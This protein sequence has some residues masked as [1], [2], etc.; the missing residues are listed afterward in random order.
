MAYFIAVFYP[1]EINVLVVLFSFSSSITSVLHPFEIVVLV[2]LFPSS[3]HFGGSFLRVLYPIEIFVLV[4][5]FLF[6]FS[7]RHFG[8]TFPRVLLVFRLFPRLAR[9]F[10][11]RSMRNP[12]C[13]G[14]CLVSARDW[15][16]IA[17]LYLTFPLLLENSTTLI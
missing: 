4:V 7:P 8:G 10:W 14:S 6:S 15:L 9:C 3:W 5:L 11:K 16:R 17:I 2:V 1:F 12:S 13:S